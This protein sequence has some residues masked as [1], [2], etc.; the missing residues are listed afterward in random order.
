MITTA[1]ILTGLT[2]TASYVVW[3][4]VKALSQMGA[5]S[6]VNFLSAVNGPSKDATVV[7]PARI[8]ADPL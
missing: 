2:G 3:E 6:V 4:L 8:R 5:K 7:M 1:S